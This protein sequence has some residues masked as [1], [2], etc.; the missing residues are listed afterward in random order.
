MK[1]FLLTFINF[2]SFISMAQ[3]ENQKYVITKKINEIEIREYLPSIYASVTLEENNAKQNS[4]FRILANYIFG[5]NS[6]NQKIAMTAPVHMQKENTEGKDA[7]TMKFVMPSKYNLNDLSKPNDPR[8]SIY[9][10]K[11]RKYAAIGY[12]GYNSDSKTDNYY[13]KLKSLLKNNKIKFSD[14]PIYLGYD[15][16]YKFWGRKNEILLEL[17]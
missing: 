5:G 9:K 13:K 1:F 8:I 3:T 10:S 11:Q 14:S 17:E 2:L 6:E 16:P 12:G 15:P 4:L 7:T